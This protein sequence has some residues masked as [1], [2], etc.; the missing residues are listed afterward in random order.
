MASEELV[1]FE[2]DEGVGVVT[3]NR[4]E[5]LNAVNWELASQLVD[6]FRDIRSR[7]EVRTIVLTGAGDRAFCA[8]GDVEW[9]SGSSDRPIPGLSELPVPRYQRKTP[10][11][12]FA[13]FMGAVDTVDQ[14]K[15]KVRVLVS[16]FGRETPVELDFLQVEKA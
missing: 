11:G 6:L 13:E 8:G 12:P 10:G 5:K 7:D 1:L 4:P 16:F 3:L 14:D 15:G 2:V 9:L